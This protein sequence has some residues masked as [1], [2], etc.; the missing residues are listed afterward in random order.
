MIG[1]VVLAGGPVNG[2]DPL[3]IQAGVTKKSLINIAGREMVRYVVE[4]LSGSRRVG[5]IVMVGLSSQEVPGLEKVAAWVPDRGELLDNVLAGLRRLGEIAPS[6]KWALISSADI[7]LLSTEAV[8]HFL[9]SCLAHEADLY[10]S[11]VE[12]TVMDS[13]FPGAGRSYVRL[14]DG[15]FAGGDLYLVRRTVNMDLGL[16]RSL[17]GARKDALRMARQLGPV[18]ILK[19][20]LRRLT[21]A[22]AEQRASRA[23]RCRGKAIITPYAEIGMDVDKPH[24]LEIVRAVLESQG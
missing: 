12:R 24:Q 9:D 17:L 23:L 7:P 2:P 19:F 18:F 13:R 1:A 16:I 5:P 11:I 21:V 10:Y 4:A 22:E 8:E 15:S 14:A 6:S 3:A 20:L